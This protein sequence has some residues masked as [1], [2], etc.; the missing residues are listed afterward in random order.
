MTEAL[1]IAREALRGAGRVVAMTGAGIS[2]ESGVPTF[3]GAGGLWRSHQ[4]TDLA[5]PQ[6]FRRDP[7]LVWEWYDWRRGLV[8][9]CA[10]NEGH[11]ALVRLEDWAEDFTLVTQNVDGLHALAG[12]RALLELHGSLWRLRCTACGGVREDR[13]HPL[14]LL[15]EC[16]ACGGLERPDVVWFGESLDAVVLARAAEAVRR[17]DVLLVVGTSGVVQ[18][19]ASL[20]WE[21][22]R[23]GG[24]VIVANLEPT[25]HTELADAF[26]RGPAGQTL[27]ALLSGVVP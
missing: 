23:A 7:R 8:G 21:C 1:E 17:A 25:E 2:A 27:P 10:P 14:V 6:A 15:P 12:S 26:V 20:A 13:T 3:R 9:A 19:A 4:A 11:R 24:V 16:P 22:K 18:P 5:T